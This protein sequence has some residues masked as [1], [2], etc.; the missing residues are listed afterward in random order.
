MVVSPQQITRIIKYQ[1][2]QMLMYVLNEVWMGGKNMVKYVISIWNK[3]YDSFN[4]Q[5]LFQSNV[6]DQCS[7]ESIYQLIST[8]DGET[9]SHPPLDIGR[10]Y[11]GDVS[12]NHLSP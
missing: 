7:N 11:L 2:H 12:K 3:I 9:W 6:Y 8:H 4:N 5:I 10:L 1:I